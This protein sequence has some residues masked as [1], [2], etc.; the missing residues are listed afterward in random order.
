[1]AYDKWPTKMKWPYALRWENNGHLR[2]ISYLRN[3]YGIFFNLRVSSLYNIYTGDNFIYP[4]NKYYKGL[5]QIQLTEMK[6]ELGK[7]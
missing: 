3:Q 4:Y 6:I 2:Q 7:Y 5:N 1:M